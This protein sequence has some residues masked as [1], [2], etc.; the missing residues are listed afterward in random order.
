MK[1]IFA[2][3]MVVVFLSGLISG[4]YAAPAEKPIELRLSHMN[5]AGSPEDQHYHRWAK[6]VEADSKGRLA[7][8]IFPGGV[9]INAFETYSGTVKGVAD[10]GA[11]YRYDRKGAELTGFISICYPGI[12]DAAIGTRILDEIRAKFPAYN[13]EWE[14]AKEL[15]LVTAGPAVLI[16]KPRPL[17]TMEDFKGLQLRIPV[18]ESADMLTALGGSPVGMPIADFPIALDKGTVHGGSVQKAAIETFKLAPAAKYCTLFSLYNPS[19]YFMVMNWDSYKKLPPD[20]QKV[21]ENSLEWAKHDIVETFDKADIAGV[22]W[23]KKQGM[24]FTTLKPEEMKKW[25]TV[26]GPVQDRWGKDEDP[27]GYPATEVLKFIRQRIDA[28]VK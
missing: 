25:L 6:K 3:P 15:Y 8:R 5:P 28:Y 23:A 4:V 27:K 1:R 13:K 9:L 19:N 26:I 10:I 12:P 24:E 18:R 21:I 20:L 2:I 14:R 17:R 11:S 22:E 16:T 7:F